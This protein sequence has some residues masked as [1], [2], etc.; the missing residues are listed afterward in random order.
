MT[1]NKAY[2]LSSPKCAMR[3]ASNPEGRTRRFPFLRLS[4]HLRRRAGRHIAAAGP[5]MIGIASTLSDDQ[6]EAPASYLSFIK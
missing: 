6:I 1:D 5:L 2:L 4:G 3:E